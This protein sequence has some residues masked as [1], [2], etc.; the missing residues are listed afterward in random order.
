M[1]DLIR[2]P[3]SNPSRKLSAA[4]M[5]AAFMSVSGLIIQ[6]IWPQWYD[7]EVWL[8][9]TPVVIFGLGWFTH[10]EATIVMTEEPK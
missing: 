4:T 5:G 10:D 7:A 9:L 2:L 8:N 1:A 6:N 3:T